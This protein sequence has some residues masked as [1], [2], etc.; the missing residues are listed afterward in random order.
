MHFVAF[1]RVSSSLPV[2]FEHLGKAFFPVRASKKNPAQR[3]FSCAGLLLPPA[4]TGFRRVRTSGPLRLLAGVGRL[5]RDGAV[6]A[7]HLSLGDDLA[8]DAGDG[9]K[10]AETE[11]GAD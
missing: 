4:L 9:L 5:G 2:P 11:L 3:G 1:L 10:D 6:G 8:V 7:H